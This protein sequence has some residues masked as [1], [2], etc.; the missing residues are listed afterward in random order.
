MQKN[1]Y[2]SLVPKTMEPHKNL[3]TLHG[4]GEPCPFSRNLEIHLNSSIYRLIYLKQDL[5]YLKNNQLVST[6]KK[7]H[8]LDFIFVLILLHIFYFCQS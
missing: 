6:E 3:C 4:I 1:V 5:C 8:T 2:F 7:P